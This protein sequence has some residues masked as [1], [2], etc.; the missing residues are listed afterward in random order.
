MIIDESF[1]ENILFNFSLNKGQAELLD[2]TFPLNSTWTSHVLDKKISNEIREQLILLRGDFSEENQKQILLNY[3]FMKDSGNIQRVEVSEKS[4]DDSNM[5]SLSIYCDGACSNNP[6]EAGSGIAIYYQ[7]KKPTLLYGAFHI[8]G[9]NNTAE[10]NAL[11]KALE[12]A[13]AEKGNFP[14]ITIYSDS[15]YSIDCISKWAYTW[16]KNNWTK[17]GGEIKNM[18]KIQVAHALYDEIKEFVT[19]KHVRGHTGEE[20]NELADRMALLAISSQT[21]SYTEFNYG[22]V[23]GILKG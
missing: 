12:I 18:E 15:Q 14:K 23:K 9:T 6:G 5:N 17:K 2:L 8:L 22:S 21:E 20:G 10:L 19:L 1:M 13:A 7:G 4:T 11:Q 3:Q 16:K